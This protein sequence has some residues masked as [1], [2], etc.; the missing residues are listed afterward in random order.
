M[1]SKF[2]IT[3]LVLFLVSVAWASVTVTH[4]ET[5]LKFDLPD[6]WEYSQDGNLFT[7]TSPDESVILMFFVGKADDA[8]DLLEN[9]ADELD[10]IISDPEITSDDVEETEINGLL[11][12]FIEGTGYYGDDEVDFDLTMVFGGRKTMSVIALG[13]L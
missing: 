4:K 2:I 13:D 10:G 3:A 12:I 8:A 11:Q 5:G 1:R 7:A 9:I 6:N